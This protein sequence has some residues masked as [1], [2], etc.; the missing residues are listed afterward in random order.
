MKFI[1]ENN[2]WGG[3]GEWKDDTHSYSAGDVSRLLSYVQPREEQEKR[4][5]VPRDA[6]QEET[7]HEPSNYRPDPI[8]SSL[9]REVERT[10]SRLKTGGEGEEC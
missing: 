1:Y 7:H 10:C 3:K 8:V 4:P 6:T 9:M 5:D 2:E